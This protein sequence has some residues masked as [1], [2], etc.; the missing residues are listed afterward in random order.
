MDAGAAIM[1]AP[2]ATTVPQTASVIAEGR[3]P[4][5]TNSAARVTDATT[6]IHP[7]S[8]TRCAGASTLDGPQRR[9]VRT[10]TLDSNTAFI[11]APFLQRPPACR[12]R[13]APAG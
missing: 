11:S 8:R 12:R 5:A 4:T 3:L 1:I 6:I 7:R 9:S 13:D 10:I 2:T